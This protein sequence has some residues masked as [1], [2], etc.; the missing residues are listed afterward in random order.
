MGRA[1]KTY[2]TKF[3]NEICEQADIDNEGIKSD[4]ENRLCEMFT[5]WEG[6]YIRN[7][8]EMDSTGTIDLSVLVDYVNTVSNSIQELGTVNVFF[9]LLDF[10]G[11]WRTSFLKECGEL[12]SPMEYKIE[13]ALR[14]C[15]LVLPTPKAMEGTR[16][17]WEK[18]LGK[19]K[20][21][22]Y[23]ERYVKKVEL[24]RKVEKEREQNG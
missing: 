21:A 10:M 24:A 15:F 13:I 3:A 8:E 11:K 17:Y 6:Q 23:Y 18:K 4:I 9:T 16:E 5:T 20:A 22:H 7:I 12:K 19:K 2:A 1:A 14:Q